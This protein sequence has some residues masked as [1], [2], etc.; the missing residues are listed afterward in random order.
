MSSIFSL[1]LLLLAPRLPALTLWPTVLQAQDWYVDNVCQNYGPGNTALGGGLYCARGSTSASTIAGNSSTAT[2]GSARGGG[3]VPGTMLFGHTIL[4]HNTADFGPNCDGSLHSA[5]YN[6]V[7][8]LTDCTVTGDETGNL[9]GVDPR[10]RDYYRLELTSPAI[11]AGDPARIERGRDL[12]GLPRL[13]DGTLDRVAVQDMGAH[14][15]SHVRLEITG[16]ATPGGT[17][18]FDSAGTAGLFVF[19]FVGIAPAD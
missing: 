10:F 17:L 14:E 12:G 18:T 8:V 11:D 7:S 6:L 13:L 1:V 9:Y 5:G 3:V 4:A 2:S 19:L 15:F 16:Q